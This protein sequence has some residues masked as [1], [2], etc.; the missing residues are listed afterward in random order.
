MKFSSQFNAWSRSVINFKSFWFFIKIF[1]EK[2]R[3]NLV[4]VKPSSIKSEAQLSN[5]P[6]EVGTVAFALHH[7]R[8]SFI[9]WSKKWTKAALVI[10]TESNRKWSFDFSSFDGSSFANHSHHTSSKRSTYDSLFMT[11]KCFKNINWP[12]IQVDKESCIGS[13]RDGRNRTADFWYAWFQSTKG[14]IS[15]VHSYCQIR[16]DSEDWSTEILPE[17]SPL[18]VWLQIQ[19]ASFEYACII[20]LNRFSRISLV[21]K[22]NKKLISLNKPHRLLPNYIDFEARNE[23]NSRSRDPFYHRILN[24]FNLEWSKMILLWSAILPSWRV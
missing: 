12:M 6:Q 20:C 13:F 4:F 16:T 15:L 9:A 5:W 21:E 18:F 17:W 24:N 10:S 1:F 23:Q 8:T 19:T 11:H 22:S 7:S 14:T 2:K 3:K